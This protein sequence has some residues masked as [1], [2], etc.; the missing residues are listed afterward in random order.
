MDF[1]A[2]REQ[3]L[4]N[5]ENY[6]TEETKI[7]VTKLLDFLVDMNEK[8]SKLETE[9]KALFAEM[10]DIRKNPQN[11]ATDDYKMKIDEIIAKANEGA[12][13]ITDIALNKADNIIKEANDKS[14]LMAEQIS[15]NQCE[16][17]KTFID[18]M[19]LVIN[20]VKKKD[21]EAKIYRKHILGIFRKTI[22]RFADTSYY[23]IRSDNKD[24]RELL[25]FF[26]VDESLQRLCDENIEKL[27]KD[28]NYQRIL[29]LVKDK[30]INEDANDF[31]DLLND[32]KITID[33]KTIELKDID[34]KD[35]EEL[36]LQEDEED[37][38]D[39]YEVSAPQ[40]KSKFLDVINQYKNNK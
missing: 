3:I 28:P 26:E 23:I 27:D 40:S 22:F 37:E 12:K 11:E 17:I 31:K 38:E 25:Q 30:P 33:N 18:K 14:L 13:K 29:K 5:I 16:D 24:F 6:N 4:A 21:E 9:N 19:E 15:E 39:V 8:R 20:E 34:I 35:L 2:L 36:A 32:E 10:N 7:V 1:K